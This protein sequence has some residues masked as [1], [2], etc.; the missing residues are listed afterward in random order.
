MKVNGGSFPCSKRMLV[1]SR[2][3]RLAPLYYFMFFFFWLVM[4]LWGGEGPLFFEYSNMS[5]CGTNWVWHMLFLNNLIPWKQ[6]DMCMSWTWFIACEMQFFLLLPTLIT[7]YYRVRE[8][9]WISIATL[10]G[11][12]SL[13]VLIVIC[14]N[15]ISASY[16]TYKDVYWTVLYEKPYARLIGYLTGVIAGCAYFTY[17]HETHTESE[18]LDEDENPNSLF[19]EEPDEKNLLY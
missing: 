8:N 4:V 10:A 2:F 11:L 9:F 7:Q 19:D 16:F 12:S 3:V 6:R 17:K 13:I 18:A 15:D 5:E 1:L 14:K